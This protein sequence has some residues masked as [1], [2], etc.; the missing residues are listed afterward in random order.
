VEDAGRRRLWRRRRFVE[1]G[2]GISDNGLVDAF[3][4]VI[5]TV[6]V[7]IEGCGGSFP[8]VVVALVFIFFHV[9]VVRGMWDVSDSN[10]F[11]VR[12]VAR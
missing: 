2:G 12:W 1:A 5:C 4:T 10:R 7:A 9:L 3:V 11:G 6:R 8:F